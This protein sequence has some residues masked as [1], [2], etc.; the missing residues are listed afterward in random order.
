MTTMEKPVATIKQVPG[1]GPSHESVKA[2][3]VLA[4]VP[5]RGRTQIA[6]GQVI[7]GIWGPRSR[8]TGICHDMAGL[9]ALR[10]W[11][12]RQGCELAD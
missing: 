9:G 8:S 6:C 2:I 5:G 12:R 10:S 4:D 3:T 7:G 11:I 1:F